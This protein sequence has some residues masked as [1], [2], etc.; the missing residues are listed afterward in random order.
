MN[1]NKSVRIAS[2]KNS[3]HYEQHSLE[4]TEDY[5]RDEVFTHPFHIM[6]S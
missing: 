2:F 6:K 4:E 5:I 1:K 3:Q